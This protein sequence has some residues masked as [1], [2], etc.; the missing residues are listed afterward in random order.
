MMAYFI[1]GRD[2][3]TE[4]GKDFLRIGKAVEA[5]EFFCRFFDFPSQYDF[6]NDSVPVKYIIRIIV[7]LT[8]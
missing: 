1:K 5:F 2:L 6:V 7:I 4:D 8:Y 3:Y